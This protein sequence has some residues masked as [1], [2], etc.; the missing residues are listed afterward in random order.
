MDTV[1]ANATG[2]ARVD[3]S[4]LVS[5][6]LLDQIAAL[7]GTVTYSDAQLQSISATIPL[8][9]LEQLAANSTVY[10][11]APAAQSTTNRVRLPKIL[12]AQRR[13]AKLN[14]LG[15]PFFIGALTSQGDISHTTNLVRSK[16]GKN[17]TGVKVGVMSDSV[18]DLAALIATGD[19][20][21]GFTVVPGQSGNPG[22]ERRHGDG[23]NRLRP[24][25]GGA[26]ILRH[27]R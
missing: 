6:D 12:P 9:A 4:A 17:G 8:A 25:A 1:Q 27:G 19:L 18:D 21:P 20:P 14:N 22:I 13:I 23:G 24:G 16:L 15:L 10:H 11:I 26:A 3:I 2:Y 5:V 7:G